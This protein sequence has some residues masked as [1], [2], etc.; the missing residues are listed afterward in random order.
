MYAADFVWVLDNGI[1]QI[2]DKG[3]IC[4]WDATR[5]HAEVLQCMEVH[6]TGYCSP[7]QAENSEIIRF[8][9]ADFT[10]FRRDLALRTL[11]LRPQILKIFACGA[12]SLNFFQ[13]PYIFFVW[14]DP[15]TPPSPPTHLHNRSQKNLVPYE[16]SPR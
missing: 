3:A 16:D 1:R 14:G 6:T 11:I 13:N 8:K 10:R 7:P 4:V 9:H 5:A 2:S 12:N 15:P